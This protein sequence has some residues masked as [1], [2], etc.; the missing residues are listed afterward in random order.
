MTPHIYLYRG[1]RLLSALIRWQTRSRYSHASMASPDDHTLVIEAWQ[2]R[3]V[4]KT[5][6]RNWDDIDAFCVV[7]VTEDQHRA[8]WAWANLQ[9]GLGYDYLGVLRFVSRTRGRENKR[10]FCSELVYQALQAAGLSLLRDIEA[11]AVS[12][13]LLALS[14]YMMQLNQT[15]IN[16]EHHA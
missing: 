12:P 8:A 11:W 16:Y 1:K 10:W 15:G 9:L 14:P 7:K 6:I 13:A 3:G 4:H 5:H 2:G